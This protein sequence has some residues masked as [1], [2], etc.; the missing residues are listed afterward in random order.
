ME[1]KFRKEAL[2]LDRESTVKKMNIREAAKK[3][4]IIV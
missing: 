3:A 4:S 1:A 2:K